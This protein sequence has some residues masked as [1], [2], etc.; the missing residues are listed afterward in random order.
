MSYG[1]SGRDRRALLWILAAFGPYAVFDLLFQETATTRYALPLVVPV[2]YL[3]A[4]G[5][6]TLPGRAG[7]AVA[8]VVA[9]AS[10]VTTMPVLRAYGRNPAP[11]FRVLADMRA[12]G[13]SLADTEAPVLAMHRR[14]ELDMRRPLAWRGDGLP[15]WSAHLPAPPKHEWMELVKYWNGGGR[16]DVWF[17]ADPPRSDLRLVD[18]H[19]LVKRGAYRWPFDNT[20]LIGGTRP[21]VMDW[22]QI[23]PP[24]WYVGEGWALT[25]ETAGVAKDE[26]RGAAK[27]P[28][29]GW[30]RRHPGAVTLMIGGR[31]LAG[32][33]PETVVTV[34]ID[35]RPVLRAAAAPGF[36]LEF[37]TLAAGALDGDGDY[38]SV[39][40][41]CRNG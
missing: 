2:A 40:G 38:A 36:F 27:A 6:A 34:S 23:S 9:L 24:G 31:N 5:W 16:A 25:P 17:L 29:R 28:I 32:S 30:I 21:D 18:C 37:V 41:G 3:A 26:G 4:Y 11:A 8:G 1:V 39:D 14:Q 20:A 7:A 12:A 22:Y 10:L 33:G 15:R 35:D 19:A 13:A